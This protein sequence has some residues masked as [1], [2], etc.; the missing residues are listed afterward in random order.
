[1][2]DSLV[3]AKL[4][5]GLKNEGLRAIF[6]S[7]FHICCDFLLIWIQNRHGHLYSCYSICTDA[8]PSKQARPLGPSKPVPSHVPVPVPVPVPSH[9]PV[10]SQSHVPVA[11]RSHVQ[12][13]YMI[14]IYGHHEWSSCMLISCDD[15]DRDMGLGPGHGTGTGPGHG[16]G[17]RTGTFAIRTRHL[18]SIKDIC[19][20]C[21]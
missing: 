17:T 15:R 18:R 9:V 3:N 13:W 21:R 5:Q 10:P 7:F 6:G 2:S 19:N 12:S 14:I 11:S 20:I 1:M 8:R 16:A 4:C